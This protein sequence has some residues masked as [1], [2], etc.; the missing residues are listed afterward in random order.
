[1]M[2]A[3]PSPEPLTSS[4]LLLFAPRQ[5]QNILEAPGARAQPLGAR[6][7]EEPP[8]AECLH[9]SSP[10]IYYEELIVH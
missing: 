3:V 2:E 5:E 10:G 4:R 9:L 7:G 1:M 8:A 6:G